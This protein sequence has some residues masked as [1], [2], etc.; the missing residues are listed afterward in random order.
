MASPRCK[1]HEEPGFVAECVFAGGDR[2]DFP[3]M[4]TRTPETPETVQPARCDE[5][6]S[7]TSCRNARNCS[8]AGGSHARRLE[9]GRVARSPG[10]KRSIPGERPS[11]P[12][13]R[14]QIGKVPPLRRVRN[15]TIGR[16]RRSAPPYRCRRTP[17]DGHTRAVTSRSEN[18]AADPASIQPAK[19]RTD[20]ETVVS[21]SICVSGLLN[22]IVAPHL[23]PSFK[24]DP[25]STVRSY[26][27]NDRDPGRGESSQET[28][29]RLRMAQQAVGDRYVV[30]PKRSKLE[31][32]V[33]GD[34]A[35]T[36]RPVRVAFTSAPRG[37]P[38]DHPTDTFSV[39]QA[40]LHDFM[41]IAR[42]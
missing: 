18:R 29:N 31:R 32:L 7:R 22:C 27:H 41:R 11:G 10:R 4:K 13:D 26:E 6:R 35:R 8:S 12:G 28:E 30:A 9:N 25:V 40:A 37:W 21:Y 14:R 2:R 3:Q 15:A 34:P 23:I 24:G 42:I 33:S 38:H 19:P 39:S 16:G 1:Q 36:H 20:A 5:G 17:H